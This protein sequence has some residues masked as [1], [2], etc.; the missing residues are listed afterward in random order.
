MKVV[1]ALLLVCH[2]I[3]A[4]AIVPF[5]VMTLAAVDGS[6]AVIVEYNGS[7]AGVRLHHRAGDFTPCLSDHRSLAGRLAATVCGAGKTDGDHVLAASS[8][9]LNTEVKKR[10]DLAAS[11]REVS[12]DVLPV[13]SLEARIRDLL[14]GVSSETSAFHRDTR[15]HGLQAHRRALSTVILLV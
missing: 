11:A 9:S 7:G 10:D 14:R 4:T 8:A 15:L 12:G 6:H 1:A 13:A 5:V 3:S 2:V